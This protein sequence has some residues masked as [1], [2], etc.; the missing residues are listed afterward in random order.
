MLKV[1]KNLPN[2]EKYFLSSRRKLSDAEIIAL[3]L[4]ST[5]SCSTM[6]TRKN[7]D[8]G[9]NKGKDNDGRK[10]QIPAKAGHL[11]LEKLGDDEE[12]CKEQDGEEV[13]RQ[14]VPVLSCVLLP[15]GDIH[16]DEDDGHDDVD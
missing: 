16:E 13:G 11:A 3:T 5:F 12:N 10:A 2:I 9:K 4:K 8:K 7:G 6:R 14:V 15:S 1:L